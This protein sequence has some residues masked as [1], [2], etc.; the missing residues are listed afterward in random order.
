VKVVVAQLVKGLKPKKLKISQVRLNI[1][2]ELRAEGRVVKK[3]FEKTTATWK[4]AKP[5]FEIAIG[6]TGTD[7]IVL[8]GPG[9][10]PEGAQKWVWLDEGTKPHTIKAKNAPNLVFRDGRGFKAKTKVKTFSSG[11]GANTG[12][13]VTKKQVAHPGIEAREWSAEIVKRRQKK[14]TRRILKAAR[15]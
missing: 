1:L 6:L 12:A 11:P 3:E 14:F 5:T 9:G 15:V 13:I 10:N 7:A 4:G 2:N 8:I